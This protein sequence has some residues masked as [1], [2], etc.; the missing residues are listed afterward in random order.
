MYYNN[1][2]VRQDRTFVRLKTQDLTIGL[3]GSHSVSKDIIATGICE[4]YLSLS[5]K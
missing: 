3:A 1:L 5:P 4:N 2:R